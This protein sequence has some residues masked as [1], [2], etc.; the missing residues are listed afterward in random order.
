MGVSVKER[1]VKNPH[2][3]TNQSLNKSLPNYFRTFYLKTLGISRSIKLNC[4]RNA[5]NVLDII[6]ASL[7]TLNTVLRVG[8]N[9]SS[10]KRSD[11]SKILLR[12]IP[13]IPQLY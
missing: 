11:S 3:R 2:L 5:L 8:R 1:R 9:L 10:P 12:T 7:T 6:K 4:L 13:K